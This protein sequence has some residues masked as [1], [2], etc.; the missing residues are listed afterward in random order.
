MG[1][2]SAAGLGVGALLDALRSGTS[3]IG[4]I[5]SLKCKGITN[6]VGAEL[7]DYDPARHFAPERLALLDRFAQFA[8]IAA[9]EALS[10]AGLMA[11][12]LRR[13]A[14]VVLGSGVGGKLT[15]DEAS[16]RLYN[17]DGRVHPLAI[18]R[19]MVSAA[20][21]QV[22]M[23]F[24]ITGP[25]FTVTSACSS[26]THAIAQ[27]MLLI[28]SGVAPVVIAG[29][30]DA[31]FCYGLY[32]AWAA[33]RL[34]AADTCRPF[35]RNRR[36]LVLGEG[37][38]I[39][40]LEDLEHA[41]AR[42]A[43]IHAELAG[44]GMTADAEHITQP[45]ADGAAQAMTLALEDGRMACE[46]VGY[47]N[48]HGTGTPMNDSVE[49]NAIKI[50]FAKHAHRFPVS[51]TKSILGHALGAAGALECIASVLAIRHGFAPPTANYVTPD[52]ACDLDC[53]PNVAR[54]VEIGAALSNSFAFGGLN[55]VIALR[56]WDA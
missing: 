28:R 27:A 7:R 51:S 39:V 26:S 5:E 10:S 8:L 17:G 50:V 21:S 38:G 22:T 6:A 37:A 11:S 14:A 43:N 45:S 2:V 9:R 53:V 32:K 52:P 34:L 24:G 56:R 1:C 13:N 20:T 42:G 54:T 36:G 3:T 4:P 23:E 35:D 31:A 46:E 29:G 25:A 18:P 33:M 44:C 47:I 55:A 48:A 16:E 40:V 12:Q 15:D 30:S 19:I 41:R 49:T